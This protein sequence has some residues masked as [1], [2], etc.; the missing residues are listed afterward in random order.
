MRPAN[1]L[2]TL[3]CVRACLRDSSISRNIYFSSENLYVLI[4]AN[5]KYANRNCLILVLHASCR[6]ISFIVS[7]WIGVGQPLC[8]DW[9][10]VLVGD[11]GV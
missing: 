5:A 8:F 1:V 6:V 7:L 9:L 2:R 11:V 10:V 4:R 3:A